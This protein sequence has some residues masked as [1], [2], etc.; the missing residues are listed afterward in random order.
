MHV[1]DCGE[2]GQAVQQSPLQKVDDEMGRINEVI[3]GISVSLG[4]IF[5]ALGL[6][7]EK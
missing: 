5:Q 7:V 2:S 3:D 1:D 6:E 4:R